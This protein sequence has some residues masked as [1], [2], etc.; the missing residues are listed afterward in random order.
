MLDDVNQ[1]RIYVVLE[2]KKRLRQ[3][4]IDAGF[5]VP[6]PDEYFKKMIKPGEFCDHLFMSFFSYI[7][8][9]DF[10]IYRVFTWTMESHTWY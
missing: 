8:Q 10:V 1:A 3:G 2:M 7:V 4:E 6:S 5:F 9:R